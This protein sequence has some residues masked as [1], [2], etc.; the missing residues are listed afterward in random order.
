MELPMF[1]KRQAGGPVG[2]D[3]DC[4]FLAAA[5]VSDGRI[6]RAAST[7][8]PPGIVS[9]GEVADPSALSAALK[10]FFARA[11]LPKA[12][13]LG[14]SNQQI[15]VRQLELPPIEDEREQ[16]AAVRFQAAETIA[17]PLDEAVLDYQAVGETVTLEGA[18]RIRYVVAAAREAMIARLVEGVRGAG[19]RPLGVD[20]NAF[21]LVRALGPAQAANGADPAPGLDETARVYCHLGG[22]TNL[23]VAVGSSCLFTRP[24]SF[25]AALPEDVELDVASFAEEIRLSIDFYMS[26]PDARWV[27]DVVLSGPG[28][29]RP[30]IAEQLT[31][32]LALPVVAV[33]PLGRLDA[34]GLPPGEDPYRYTVAVG[35]A[36]GE[37]R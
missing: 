17:M 12:V 13:R 16:A 21:A 30:G 15:V 11:E 35:L 26:Q 7:E 20:L 33:E 31:G 2:L 19:L 36:L 5:A 3:L 34:A 24:L 1:K 14:V 29:R 8:L 37:D 32:P 22:I 18:K 6:A 23:A 25:D 28:A 10:E 27:S 4:S 9:D